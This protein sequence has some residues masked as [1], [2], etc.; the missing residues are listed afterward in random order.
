MSLNS[1]ATGSDR[2]TLDAIFRHPVSHGLAWREV[3]SLINAI[4]NADERHNGEFM[5]SVGE[6]RMPT[7]R[8]HNKDLT[9]PEVME[10]RHFL[11]RAGWSPDSAAA[12]KGET[13]QDGAAPEATRLIIVIDH[14]GA[15][16]FRIDLADDDR[17]G[18]TP[19]DPKH[20]LHHI[21]RKLRDADRDETYPEDTRFF[22]DVAAAVSQ[23]GEIVVIGHGKGQSNE[24]DQLSAYLKAHHKEAYA[25]IVTTLSADI[26]HLSLPELLELGRRAFAQEAVIGS[27]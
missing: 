17:H 1:Q 12:S 8:P 22:D 20:L 15:R 10:I 11:I 6:E 16:I 3:V 7:R 27:A 26:P 19:Y 23:G 9:A 25:R 4:G 14:A 2:R 13:A 24:A 21:E 18:I 5:F